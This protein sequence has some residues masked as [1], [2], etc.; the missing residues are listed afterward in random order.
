MRIGVS[1]TADCARELS[2]GKKTTMEET[3]PNSALCAFFASTEYL[4]GE[5]KGTTGSGGRY[6][7]TLIVCRQRSS[8]YLDVTFL[9]CSTVEEGIQDE[10]RRREAT[11]AVADS[12]PM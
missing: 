9:V 10:T 5:G 1:I 3:A 11:L 7:N 12:E 4:D 2:G 6:D 8:T